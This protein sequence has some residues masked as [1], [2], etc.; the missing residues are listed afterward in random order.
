M[1]KFKFLVA[2]VAILTMTIYSCSDNNPVN[3]Q[4]TAE[5]SISLRAAL[6]KIKKDNNISGRNAEDQAMCFNF[7]YPITL[8]YNNGTQVTVTSFDGLLSLLTQENASLYLEGIAFPFQVQQEGEILTISNEDD[9]YLLIDNCG[10]NTVSD[11]FYIFDC[12]DIVYPF[13]LITEN[14]QT[15]VINNQQEFYTVITD[16]NNYVVDFVYPISLTGNGQ[17][18]VINNLYELADVLSQCDIQNGCICPAVYDP[19]CVNDPVN[20]IT[21]TFGNACQA[22]CAGY[23]TSDFI[24]CDDPVNTINFGAALGTCFNVN[25]PVQIQHQGAIVDVSTNGQLLQYW[26]PAQSNIP[27]FVYPITVSFLNGTPAGNTMTITSQAGFEAA[28][29]NNC[30]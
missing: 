25:Y 27:A 9:F 15:V 5:K 18:V 24:T 26:F 14:N 28:I 1:K 29:S 3:E 4:K 2:F 13:S 10:Y 7:V 20:F 30:N 6:G 12:Y 11:D 23:T 8:S 19:V 22:E 16:G 21:L 17:D